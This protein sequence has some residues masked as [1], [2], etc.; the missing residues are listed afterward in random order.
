[1]ATLEKEM[2]T[3]EQQLPSLL[4]EHRGQFVL[5]KDARIVDTFASLDDALK[6]GYEEFET[7]PFLVQQVLE[8]DM[9]QNFTSFH[10]GR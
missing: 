10:L 3:F 4:G 9:P 8:V 7:A 6:R 1:M 5:I 2:M